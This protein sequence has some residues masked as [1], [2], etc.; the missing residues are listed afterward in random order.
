MTDPGGSSL[1]TAPDAA[2]LPA[3]LA[4]CGITEDA[5][6][7][8]EPLG[9]ATYNTALRLRLRD[10]RRLVL[11]IA[12]DPAADRLTYERDLLRTE[13]A[14]HRAAAAV[15]PV[16]GVVA[17]RRGG[18]AVD[19]DVLL[20]DELPGTNWHS[21]TV[22][23]AEGVALRR[24]LGGL[25]A[26][27]HRLHA[28]GFGYPQFPLAPDWPTAFRGMMGAL[29]ADAER[30]RTDQDWPLDRIAAALDRHGAVLEDVR[31]PALVHF[32]LWAGNILVSDGRITGVVDGERAFW[33]DPLAELVSLA[34]FGDVTDSAD[35][36]HVALLAGYR[37]AGGHLDLDERGRRRLL[38]YRC[39]LYLIMLVESVT[40][41]Y[42]GADHLATA[43]LTARAVSQALAELDRS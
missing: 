36:Q 26:G 20:L 27:L 21:T 1:P 16:P 37:A 28:D 11:K 18:R 33:G 29:L 30:L 5:I 17:L 40:R 42:A 12:P 25:L 38:L 22:G 43:R 8:C 41:G 10:G 6:D 19:R 15:L 34:L 9:Q 14:F 31:R 39:H 4:A 13:A 2:L 35:P 24:E 23:S 7:T 3:A 32:D